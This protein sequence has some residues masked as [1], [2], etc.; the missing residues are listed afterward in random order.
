MLILVMTLGYCKVTDPQSKAEN[1]CSAVPAYATV[2]AVEEVIRG[3][4]IPELKYGDPSWHELRHKP[5]W[6]KGEGGLTVVIPSIL[7]ERWVCNVEFAEGRVSKK[8][9]LHID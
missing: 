2:S 7:G 8:E 5:Y 4:G 6:S 9:V 3:E 1:I